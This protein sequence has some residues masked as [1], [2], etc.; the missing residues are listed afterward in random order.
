MKNSK[1][2]EPS[3]MKGINR[4]ATEN[5]INPLKVWFGQ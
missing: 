1:I 2:D 4:L 5:F 3:L